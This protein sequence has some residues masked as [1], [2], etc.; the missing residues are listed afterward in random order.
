M[1]AA[2]E[3]CDCGGAGYLLDQTYG[4]GDLP[5]DA[6][7]VQA[8]DQCRRF[9]GDDTAALAAYWAEDADAWGYGLSDDE[10]ERPGDYWVLRRSAS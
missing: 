2:I 5:D 3:T 6:V 7:N 10:T 9:D 8:C 1:I 4:Y